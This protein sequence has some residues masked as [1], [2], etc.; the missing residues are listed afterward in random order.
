VAPETA[1]AT[2]PTETSSHNIISI[3]DVF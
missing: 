1:G 3:L 2:L